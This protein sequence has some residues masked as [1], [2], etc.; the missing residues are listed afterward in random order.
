MSKETTAVAVTDRSAVEAGILLGL[1]ENCPLT[2]TDIN[3]NLFLAD[4]QLVATAYKL[5]M[6]FE[7]EDETIEYINNP[8]YNEVNGQRIDKWIPGKRTVTKKTYKP[9]NAALKLLL[10]S[11]LAGDFQKINLRVKK[12]LNK[13]DTVEGEVLSSASRLLEEM[14]QTKKVKSKT[15]GQ[16][17]TVKSKETK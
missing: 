10:Q 7:T 8:K 17:K 1:Q 11:R 12:N 3:E 9:D 2:S 16:K 15:V 4:A 13:P 14:R 5:A 6:G